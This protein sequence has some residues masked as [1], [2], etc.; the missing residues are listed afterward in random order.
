MTYFAD[1]AQ[2]KLAENRS[3][4]SAPDTSSVAKCSRLTTSGLIADRHLRRTGSRTDHSPVLP[5][6]ACNLGSAQWSGPTHFFIP[7]PWYIRFCHSRKAA[8]MPSRNPLHARDHMETVRTR[9]TAQGDTGGC[10]PNLADPP[11]LW[12]IIRFRFETP[13]WTAIG[14]SKFRSGLGSTRQLL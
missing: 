8:I 9:R 7:T 1:K 13:Y 4:L 10:N 2:N 3:A 14:Q 6:S 12:V 5:D 11:G